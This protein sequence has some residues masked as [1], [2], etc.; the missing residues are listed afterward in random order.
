MLHPFVL[1]FLR[2]VPACSRGPRGTTSSRAGKASETVS[3]GVTSADGN[4]VSKRRSVS[5]RKRKTLVVCWSCHRNIDAGQRAQV[6]GTTQ[7]GTQNMKG[8]FGRRVHRVD[9]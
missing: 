2:H 4:F 3:R 9:R 1:S 7:D 5:A 6:E 8:R